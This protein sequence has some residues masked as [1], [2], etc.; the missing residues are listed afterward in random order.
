MGVEPGSVTITDPDNPPAHIAKMAYARFFDFINTESHNALTD[1]IIK[2]YDS[3]IAPHARAMQKLI[4]ADTADGRIT[5][6]CPEDGC[7]YEI[8]EFPSTYFCKYHGCEMLPKSKEDALP[9][10]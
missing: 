8:L 5:Y 10:A 6:V 1:A 4:K 7:T 9:L 3:N 2:A